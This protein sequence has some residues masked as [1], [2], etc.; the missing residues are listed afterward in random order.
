[1][2][3]I[4]GRNQDLRGVDDMNH[5]YIMTTGTSLLSRYFEKSGG[6]TTIEYFDKYMRS[7]G[8]TLER[9]LT[10]KIDDWLPADKKFLTEKNILCWVLSTYAGN[11][12]RE[13]VFAE[14]ATLREILPSKD[15]QFTILATDTLRGIFCGLMLA[16]LISK[17][18][19]KV[20]TNYFNGQNWV[21]TEFDLGT[22]DNNDRYLNFSKELTTTIEVFHIP[23]LNPTIKNEFE[24]KGISYLIRQLVNQIIVTEDDYLPEIIFTGG[25][26][27]CI[28][29]MTQVAG[30]MGGIPMTAL[31]EE[32]KN[33][34]RIEPI[35]S[36]PD[37]A[38]LVKVLQV[39]F[40]NSTE[41]DSWSELNKLYQKNPKKRDLRWE[42]LTAEEKRLF[43][44]NS[45]DLNLI[46]IALQIYAELAY[47]N[48]PAI[49][50]DIK[51]HA[52]KR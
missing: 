37:T 36:P 45:T 40:Q 22:W 47:E 18:G 19:S 51:N 4:N 24:S 30:W 46:G 14:L 41:T 1:M 12:D 16:F 21:F 27:A 38:L 29:I 10:Q 39:I 28:P 49:Q 50:Q 25:F 6:N 5:K 20:R 42:M 2:I 13:I 26:K 32:S 15:D 33:N 52:A 8:L 35:S 48:V 7:N 3:N 34:V 9:L 31:Y 43:K 17:P 23:G 44:P 11:I